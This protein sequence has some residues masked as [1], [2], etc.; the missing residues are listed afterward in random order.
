K[1]V[2]GTV[3]M[4]AGKFSPVPPMHWKLTREGQP[5]SVPFSCVRELGATWSC[6]C[7]RTPTVPTST[8]G[9]RVTGP[10]TWI[11]YSTWAKA[12]VSPPG[13]VMLLTATGTITLPRLGLVGSTGTC[14]PSGL[15]KNKQ[16]GGDVCRQLGG[17]TGTGTNTY[18]ETV[19][20]SKPRKSP[21]PPM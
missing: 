2:P 14:E 3:F 5:Y 15:V 13:R 12:D 4:S 6:D 1:F 16:L 17:V 19:R 7:R 10:S 11:R 21:S 9:A 8:N 18:G 20:T